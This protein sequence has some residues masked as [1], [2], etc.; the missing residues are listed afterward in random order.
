M[1]KTFTTLKSYT[2]SLLMMAALVFTTMGMT[3]CEDEYIAS[4][5]EGIWSG[6]VATEVFS[7][8]YG[9]QTE[10]TD[11]DI[12]FYS[13]P[14]RYAS[15]RGVEYDYMSRWK[16]TETYFRY[17]VKNRVIYIDY[18]DGTHIA[19]ANYRLN[20]NYFRGTFA[21][22]RTGEPIADFRFYKIHDIRAKKMR[23]YAEAD[24]DE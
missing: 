14:Y 2:K 7:N 9:Y 12:E 22:Y 17:E 19:I 18:E 20:D 24:T 13:D 8:R 10:Y 16:Y 4:T 5:L 21:D 1:K 23:N 11:V 3:S 15:G 6:E